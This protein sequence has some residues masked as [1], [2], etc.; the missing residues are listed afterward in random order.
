[1]AR[2]ENVDDVR[3]FWAGVVAITR[4]SVWIFFA[5]VR[6][7]NHPHASIDVRML[8]VRFEMGLLVLVGLFC[9][10]VV[11]HSNNERIVRD[12]AGGI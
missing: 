5:P 2:F 1:M 11:I 9:V 12:T 6:L 8:R 7:A 4:I 3:C 10:L